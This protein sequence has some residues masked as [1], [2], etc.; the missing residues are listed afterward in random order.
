V[1][2]LARTRRMNNKKIANEDLRS[3]DLR[4]DMLADEELAELRRSARESIRFFRD[5]FRKNPL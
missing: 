5:F 3:P 2:E 1:W 4:A